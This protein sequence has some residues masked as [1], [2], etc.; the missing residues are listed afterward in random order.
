M[1]NTYNTRLNSLILL[2]KRAVR[3]VGNIGW[4]E[5]STEIFEQYRI[6]KL[7]DLVKYQMCLFMY[8]S[9]RGIK[10]NV[11]SNLHKIKDLHEY[12]KRSK[13]NFFTHHASVIL[14]KM[15]VNSKGI[16]LWNNLPENIKEVH[17]L[18]YLKKSKKM[19]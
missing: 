10:Q 12:N 5:H 2:Q 3:I 4:S 19:K 7:C 18:M 15:S 14:R 16:T 8:K 17:H 11:Q 9:N 1:G 13:N 6:L